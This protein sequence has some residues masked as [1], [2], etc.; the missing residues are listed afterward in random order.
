[1]I[2]DDV[3]KLNAALESSTVDHFVT[4][5]NLDTSWGEYVRIMIWYWSD[6]MLQQPP[7]LGNPVSIA[8]L[9]DMTPSLMEGKS[10]AGVGM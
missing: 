10:Y 2:K 3:D 1:V 7:V 8:V 5:V 4:S 9:F 6:P